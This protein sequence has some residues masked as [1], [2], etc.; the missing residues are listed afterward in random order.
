LNSLTDCNILE[1]VN[2]SFHI[3]YD[4]IKKGTQ[5]YVKIR[6]STCDICDKP[7][8]IHFQI[9]NIID[10]D[11][12]A[13][14]RINQLINDNWKDIYDDVKDDYLQLANELLV[15]LMTVFFSK[16]SLEEAFDN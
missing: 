7:E 10:G 16:F 13:S 12:Q 4:E 2:S 5:T 15:K 6:T 3:T 8:R 11:E 14:S 1:N 9:D